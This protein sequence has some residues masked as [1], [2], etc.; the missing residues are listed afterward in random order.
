MIR[1]ILI[2]TVALTWLLVVARP[3]GTVVEAWLLDVVVYGLPQAPAIDGA[4]QPAAA[5]PGAEA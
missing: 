4:E 3:V 2:A 5:N 1:S